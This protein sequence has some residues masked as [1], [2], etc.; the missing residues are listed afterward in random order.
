MGVR[1]R[2]SVGYKGLH[3][4]R[5]EGTVSL[6]MTTRQSW[7]GCAPPGVH[8]A[9]CTTENIYVATRNKPVHYLFT[10]CVFE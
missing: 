10:C 4:G 8:A 1:K 7:N 2:L 9:D 5:S 3:R 6:P